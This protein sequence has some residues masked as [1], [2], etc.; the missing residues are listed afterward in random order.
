[1]TVKTWIS[2][3]AIAVIAAG[4][5]SRSDVDALRQEVEALKATQAQLVKRL[6]GNAAQPQQAPQPKALPASLDLTGT[7][8][9]GSKSASLVLVEFSDYECPFCIR[10]FTQTAPQIDAAYVQTGKIRYGFRDFPIAENHPEAIRAH[11]AARCAGEQGKFWELHPRL[12]SRAGSHQPADLL[13][14]AQEAG[15]NTGAFSAC[16]AADKYTAVIRQSSAFTISLG[17]DGT[18]FFL[19][20]RMDPGSNQFRP[21]GRLSG[22]QPFAQFQQA[23]ETALAQK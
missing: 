7:E 4:C 5:A 20:G 2:A 11:V 3:A 12:F 14:R 1:M 21:M 19:I 13:A 18:P 17:G 9:R 10:H 23:I 16:V 22:A 15:L 8:M 6:G